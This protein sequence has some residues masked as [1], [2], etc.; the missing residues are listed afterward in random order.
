MSWFN[1]KT[2]EV[3]KAFSELRNSVYKEGALDQR[4]KELISVAASTLMRCERCTQIH[5]ERAKKQ[6]ATDE[7][8]AEAVV[9]AMFVAAGSQL[10][11]SE[12]YDRILGKGCEDKIKTEKSVE[13]R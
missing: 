4:T 3:A 2:P 10:S 11:W 7:M 5:A 1:E 9:C 12:V 6:G 8:I 13:C